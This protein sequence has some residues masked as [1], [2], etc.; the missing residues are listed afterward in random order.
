MNPFNIQVLLNKREQLLNRV[1]P[2]RVLCIEEEVDFELPC[3]LLDIGVL[4]NNSIVHEQDDFLHTQVLVLSY[5]FKSMVH[6]V[7]K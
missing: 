6:E 7:L 4:V 1:E 3:S 2:R 5:A